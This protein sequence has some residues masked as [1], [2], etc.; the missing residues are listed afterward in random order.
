MSINKSKL[1]RLIFEE[2]TRD[3][4]TEIRQLIDKE[5]KK[6]LKSQQTKDIVQDEIEKALRSKDSKQDIAD[7]TKKVLKTLYR[8]MSLKHPYMI[9][10]IKI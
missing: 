8:D 1:Y 3:D 7:I 10:R 4:K 2:L 6:Q 9:D 5:V